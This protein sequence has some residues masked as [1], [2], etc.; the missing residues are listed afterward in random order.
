MK[1]STTFNQLTALGKRLA[2]VLT[3]LLTMGIGQVWGTNFT[4]AGI[5]YYVNTKSGDQWWSVSSTTLQLGTISSFYLKGFWAEIANGNVCQNT[6]MYYRVNGVTKN[7]N[8]LN[9]NDWNASTKHFQ[10]ESMDENVLSGLV[11]GN[12]T[13]EIWF[14]NGE[15]ECNVWYSNNS[16]NYKIT[17]TYNPTYT[18]TVKAG[19]GG[20]VASSSVTA[21]NIDAVTLPKATPNAG[22]SFLNWAVT[23]GDIT[24]SNANSASAA[25]VK[26]RSVGTVTASF[27]ANQ[28][29]VTL[30]SQS[31]T[32]GTSSVTATYGQA[33]PAATMPTR[34]GYTFNG[35]FDAT[36]GGTQYYKADGT[37]AR[38]WN[39]TSNTTLYAQW[40]TKSYV[41]TWVVDGIVKQTGGVVHGSTPVLPTLEPGQI[42][43]DKFVG[44]VTAPIEGQL[45]DASTL[46]IYTTENLPVITGE[47]TFYAVFADY[48]N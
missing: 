29:T 40:T 1:Q 34:D 35:Y 47:T 48:E 17:F 25:T 45:K 37:S 16:S 43:G 32:G 9:P 28:Y 22:Y 12:Y 23:T 44:W 33:M 31:G 5:K 20:T 14:S 2:M 30:N 4:G 24:L 41:I 26:A 3:I 15:G 8:I 6:R 18:V 38:T 19:T 10:T 7:Y 27:N 21:G 39:I 46:T 13:L 36:S 42:C 11:G